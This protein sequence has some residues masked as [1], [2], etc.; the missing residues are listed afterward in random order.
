MMRALVSALLYKDIPW[1]QWT[2]T[3]KFLLWLSLILGG[4]GWGLLRLERS[5]KDSG[6]YADVRHHDGEW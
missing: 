3:L 2:G 1:W 6:A 4:I 5:A